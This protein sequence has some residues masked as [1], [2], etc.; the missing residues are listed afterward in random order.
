M[1]FPKEIEFDVATFNGDLRRKVVLNS[2]LTVILGPNGA[3]KTHILRALKQPLLA[4]VEGKKAQFIS[5]G[6]MGFLE[7]YR[8]DF[9]GRRGGRP[10]YERA[11]HGD[12][13]D[14]ARRHQ[15]ETLD[16]GFQALTERPD[17][18]IKIQER[19]RKLFKR[20]LVVEW[21]AGSLK[22]SFARID[23]EA[24]PYSSGREASGLLHLVGILAA[25]YDDEVGALLIDEPEVSLHP[26]LQA[27]LLKEILSKAGDPA[28]GKKIIVIATHSTEMVR[29]Q[30]P[31]D[32]CSLV[33]SYDLVVQPVQI[34]T[35][36]G[37]LQSR[38][39]ASLIARMGQEHKLALFCKRPL[40][41]EGPSDVI[42][43]SGLALATDTHLEAAGSQ[44]LPVVG[45][46]QMHVV[47]RLMRL[48]G[49]E[50]IVLADA[51]GLA[52]GL[53]LANTFLTNN[54]AADE[55]AN[56]SGAR[57]AAAVASAVYG[58]FSQLVDRNWEAIAP[59]A[60]EHPYWINQKDG[61]EAQAKRRA[62]FC[63]L[64]S[65]LGLIWTMQEENADWQKIRQRLSAV[66]DLLEKVGCFIL[67]KGSVE[68]YFV[69][70]DKL[71]SIGKPAAAATE[72]EWIATAT[73]EEIDAEYG[74]LVRCITCAADTDK[75]NEAEALRDL[76]LSIAA[77]ALAKFQAGSSMQD[78][79]VSA[80]SLS[81]G[82]SS[83]FELSK[84][85]DGLVVGLNSKILEVGSFPITLNPDADVIRVVDKALGLSGS[86]GRRGVK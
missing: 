11:H 29:V 14:V 74:D 36:A 46:G 69:A 70:A 53:E 18:L 52:D 78:I 63:T 38:A 3:G 84:D 73:P 13:G 1:L 43:A 83:L 26:Q 16:S 45:K 61:N 64:F 75:I 2:G 4:L 21:D 81:A 8:S 32:L 7:Q 58:D 86:S 60:K 35:D 56:I 27:F 19:L 55:A 22:I 82:K 51:D 62:A 5:A 59:L 10:Q 66:L 44:L 72:L 65:D 80:R 15:I 28:D 33:F 48:L 68:S 79:Q 23:V 39:I 76:L 67:R 9:D 24:L 17:V 42:I 57:S 85:G 50:P 37:E 31:E 34:S 77:P 20:E 47:S 40:L 6:R 12:K 71:T 54:T 41:V 25:L 30:R 49:K